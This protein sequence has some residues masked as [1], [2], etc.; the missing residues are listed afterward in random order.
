MK[1]N[2]IK[3][4]CFAVALL[5]IYGCNCG[6]STTQNS[7]QVI[8]PNGPDIIYTNSNPDLIILP[9]PRLQ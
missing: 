5:F 2:I 8:K 7:P 3:T 1:K 9:K 6:C 4:M